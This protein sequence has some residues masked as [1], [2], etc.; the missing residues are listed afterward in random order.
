[1]P[2]F[3]F[4]K[5]LQAAQKRETANDVG[6]DLLAEVQP[7]RVE[8]SQSQTEIKLDP[9]SLE[10]GLGK[11]GTGTSS[12]VSLSGIERLQVKINDLQSQLQVNAPGYA[13]L[14]HEIHRA[15]AED[16][17]LV[18]LLKEEEIGVI[19]AGLSK[20]KSIV[21]ADAIKNKVTSK[22]LSKLGAD[23]F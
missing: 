18:H 19:I 2:D 3:N 13:G 15:L 16:E 6:S 12:S 22:Q 17:S 14:L 9:L 11:P 21:I 8:T 5:L 10:S 20:R 7:A 1:M 23:D 4:G